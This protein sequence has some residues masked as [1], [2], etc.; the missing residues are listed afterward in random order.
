LWAFCRPFSVVFGAFALL[1]SLFLVI[2]LGLTALDRTLNHIDCGAACGFILKYP[3]IFN[4]LD[5]AL[6]LLSQYFPVDYLVLSFIVLYIYFS[7][8]NAV[9]EIGIRCFCLNMFKFRKGR[10][11]PQALM[12]TSIILM[13]STL[14]LNNSIVTLAPTYANFGSQTYMPNGT[15]TETDCSINAPS[16]VC[17]MTQVGTIVH[18]TNLTVGFFGI[19]FYGF[20]WLFVL[21]FLVS[22]IIAGVRAKKSNVD[23]YSDDDEEEED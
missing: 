10:T 20:M 2:S 15:T 4:P 21:G 9:T 18:S 7:T 3:V 6:I 23:D 1:L 14:A 5:K 22:I 19:V 11:D 12:T 16:G 13:L 8:M 17:I